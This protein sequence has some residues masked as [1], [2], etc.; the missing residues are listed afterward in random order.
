MFTSGAS[1]SVNTTKNLTELLCR[2]KSTK[3]F[4]QNNLPTYET[5]NKNYK[6]SSL[7][8]TIKNCQNYAY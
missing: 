3:M 5:K 7:K 4:L 6:A 8:K 1:V 2:T